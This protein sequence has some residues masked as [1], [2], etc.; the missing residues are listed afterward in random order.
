MFLIHNVI[1]KSIDIWRSSGWVEHRLLSMLTR[2]RVLVVLSSYL[3][4]RSTFSISALTL[5]DEH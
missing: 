3:T 4:F 1:L 5:S 2:F